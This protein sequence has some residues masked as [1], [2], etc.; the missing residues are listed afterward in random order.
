MRM[1]RL[2]C[3]FVV[4]CLDSIIPILAAAKMLW[5]A[6][7]C[8]WAGRFESYLVENCEDS[9]SWHG[10]NRLATKQSCQAP[11]IW[12]DALNKFI[13][14]IVWKQGTH[15]RCE[16]TRLNFIAHSFAIIVKATSLTP[17]SR[18]LTSIIDYSLY[19]ERQK[20]CNICVCLSNF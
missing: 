10:S 4:R 5:L 20:K 15:T 12:F 17:S 1:R 7:L 9:F 2:I 18:S 8:S 3:V 16:Y 6:G 14:M 11:S 13:K 19:T